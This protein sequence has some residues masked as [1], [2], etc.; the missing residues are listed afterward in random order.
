MNNSHK[1]SPQ[2]QWR[3]LVKCKLRFKI[4]NC[5]YKPPSKHCNNSNLSL[6]GQR[7]IQNSSEANRIHTVDEKPRK[8]TAFYVLNMLL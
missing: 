5:K 3:K 7:R 8:F 6:P 1:R 2:K 4:Y